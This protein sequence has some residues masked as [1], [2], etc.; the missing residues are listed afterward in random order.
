MNETSLCLLA[1]CMS[2]NCTCIKC[3][4][5]ALARIASFGRWQPIF[6]SMM[7][8]RAVIGRWVANGLWSSIL[9]GNLII[10]GRLIWYSYIRNY[11][12]A[13]LHINHFFIYDKLEETKQ[14]LLNLQTSRWNCS[15]LKAMTLQNIAKN[16]NTSLVRCKQKESMIRISDVYVMGDSV[17]TPELAFSQR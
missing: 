14:L 3:L 2:F 12:R 11:M 7:A 6:P 17:T 16:N 4:D 5:A 9:K 15:I 10:K 13:G 1:R 8:L